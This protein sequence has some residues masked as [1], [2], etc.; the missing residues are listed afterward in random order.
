[1]RRLR[2]FRVGRSES[3]R[4]EPWSFCKRGDRATLEDQGVL[5]SVDGE[6]VVPE[7]TTR[8]HDVHPDVAVD[9]LIRACSVGPASSRLH[10]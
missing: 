4:G 6:D 1:M 8:G 10:T 9:K 3:E 7:Q 5:A 2:A